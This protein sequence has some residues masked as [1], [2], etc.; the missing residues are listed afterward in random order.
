MQWRNKILQT[1]NISR[2]P[3]ILKRNCLNQEPRQLLVCVISK[4]TMLWVSS[5]II[6]IEF[7]N[8]STWNLLSYNKLYA[9]AEKIPKIFKST[10]RCLIFC[11][12][13]IIL[14]I[15][16]EN[17]NHYTIII[18]CHHYDCFL[19][20]SKLRTVSNLKSNFMHLKIK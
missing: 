4:T 2:L 12:Y 1:R 17:V 7:T 10:R 6:W 18:V 20:E 5:L 19:S 9:I 16:V 3:H 15:E 13:L 14:I 11:H 8:G